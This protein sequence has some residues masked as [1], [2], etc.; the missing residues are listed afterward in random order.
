MIE[1]DPNFHRIGGR[2]VFDLQNVRYR[3]YRTKWKEWPETCSV[4]GFPLHLDIESTNVCNLRCPFCA[5][6]YNRYRLGFMS[7]RTWRSILDEAERNELYSLKFTYRGEPLLHPDIARMVKGAK[8]AGILDV[9]FNTNAVRLTEPVIRDLIDAGLDRISISFEGF[10]KELYERC[11]VGSSYAKV[12]GNIANLKRIRDEMGAEKPLIRVQTVLIPELRGREEEYSMFW[13]S[14][15]DEVACLDMMDE[16]GNPDHRGVVSPWSC[17]QIFQ[18]MTITWDGV[19]LPCVHDI[20]ERLALGTIPETSIRDAWL[21]ELE[22]MYRE[23]HCSSRAHELPA[24][25]RCAYR[26]MEIGKLLQGEC[27]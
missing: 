24:C 26:A 6:T 22:R 23:K 10:E 14:R 25:D 4:G 9:Y 8:E 19:I 7:G 11:R 15:A 3:E 20:H 12:L 2:S 21:G 13:E 27:G 17:H 5:T 16:A 18:R 1:G